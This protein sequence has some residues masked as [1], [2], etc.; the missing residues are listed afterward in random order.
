M[1]E[2]LKR[3]PLSPKSERVQENQATTVVETP[4]RQDTETDVKVQVLQNLVL[5]QRQMIRQLLKITTMLAEH[6]R[7][8]LIQTELTK[9]SNALDKIK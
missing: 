5:E 7:F 3:K 2:F 8:E 6:K 4:A 1:F 9:L